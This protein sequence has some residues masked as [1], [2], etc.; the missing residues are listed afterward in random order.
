MLFSVETFG[1]IVLTL[2]IVSF[3]L[4]IQKIN[5][6]KKIYQAL[7]NYFQLAAGSS[8]EESLDFDIIQ[9]D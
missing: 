4:Q 3:F 1:E 2:T 5:V 8:Q 9:K 7:A 6:I